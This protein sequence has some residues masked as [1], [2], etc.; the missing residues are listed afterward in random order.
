MM[1][2]RDAHIATMD[3]INRYAK[4]FIT[5]TLE[6]EIRRATDEGWFKAQVDIRTIQGGKAT[7]REVVRLLKESG[8][9]AEHSEDYENCIYVD[10]E[11]ANNDI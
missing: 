3:N 5:N 10:W 4:E 8:Y 2:A 9:H 11:D 7:A 1:S 6:A